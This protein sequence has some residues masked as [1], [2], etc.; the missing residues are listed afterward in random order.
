MCA[1]FCPQSLLHEQHNYDPGE[2]YW[3]EPG[4]DRVVLGVRVLA[5]ITPLLFTVKTIALPMVEQQK[6]WWPELMTIKRA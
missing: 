2:K 3:N 6:Q 1:H 5:A 4:S